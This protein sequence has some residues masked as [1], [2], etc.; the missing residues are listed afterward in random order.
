MMRSGAAPLFRHQIA[1][2]YESRFGVAP[3][4]YDCNPSDG[5][6]E[7]TVPGDQNL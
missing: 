2:A 7:R 4:I 3:R 1:R 5:A 6:G